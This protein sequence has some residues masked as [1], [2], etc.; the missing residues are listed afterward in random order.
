MDISEFRELAFQSLPLQKR[1]RTTRFTLVRTSGDFFINKIHN[2]DYFN[3]R[4]IPIEKNYRFIISS[5]THEE[6]QNFK[7][8]FWQDIDFLKIPR[9]DFEY[10]PEIAILSGYNFDEFKASGRGKI[11]IRAPENPKGSDQLLK[12]MEENSRR[13]MRP[14]NYTFSV[15][16]KSVSVRSDLNFFLTTH[17]RTS[18]DLVFKITEY[19]LSKNKADFDLY[20]SLKILPK[21]S[22]QEFMGMKTIS[23]AL[24]EIAKERFVRD[25]SEW[26]ILG[27]QDISSKTESIYLY[28][29]NQDVPTFRVNFE[30]NKIVL[31]PTITSKVES[32]VNLKEALPTEEIK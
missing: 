14:Y 9:N 32:I 5:F 12:E 20:A 10:L 30:K 21:A 8:D 18:I 1:G 6:Y 17:E 19:V 2:Q 3:I 22:A 26:F 15:S 27:K 4:S 31:V 7:E 13:G 11:D 23:F 29:K 16:G 28:E 24:P 25:I